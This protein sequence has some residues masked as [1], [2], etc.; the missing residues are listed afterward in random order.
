MTIVT[1]LTNHF[2]AFYTTTRIL[3]ASAG[4]QNRFITPKTM[5]L[6]ELYCMTFHNQLLPQV[7]TDSTSGI[8]AKL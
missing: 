3:T 5:Q 8:A 2:L 6:A 7:N 1:L 4:P